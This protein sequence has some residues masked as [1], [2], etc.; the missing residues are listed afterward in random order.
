MNTSTLIASAS[1]LA[2]V[3]SILLFWPVSGNTP[4]TRF[5]W[6]AVVHSNF[7]DVVSSMV[8]SLVVRREVFPNVSKTDDDG[9]KAY[10]ITPGRSLAL[11][12]W[13]G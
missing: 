7:S 5:D 10:A 4:T 2:N 12:Y 6:C 8:H 9:G 11:E 13:L 1:G 3:A